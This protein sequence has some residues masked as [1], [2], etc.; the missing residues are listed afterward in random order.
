MAGRG[1]E[2][3]PRERHPEWIP[4]MLATLT[5]T[6]F[7]D[8]SWIFERKLDGIRLLAFRDRER[9]RLLTR[10][11]LDRKA[12][13]PH[14]AEAL[15]EQPSRDFVVDGE[16]VSMK[17]GKDS[18]SLL[19]HGTG[20]IVYF[21]FDLLHLDGRN[22]R[23]LPVLERKRLLQGGFVFSPRPLRITPHR[24]TFGERYLDEACS[25]GWEGLIA[26]EISSTYETK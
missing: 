19:Q 11:K 21:V 12:S 9:L 5:E 8:R 25:K 2:G 18:F 22:T 6:R 14:V 26:K 17:G 7:S 20:S 13:F 3:L 15:L 23:A 10:N 1:D 16:V 24:T 4:P